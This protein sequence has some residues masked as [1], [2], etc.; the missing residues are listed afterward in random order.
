M[1]VYTCNSKFYVVNI[2]DA[3]ITISWQWD[4]P[5]YLTLSTNWSLNNLD[6]E[7]SRYMQKRSQQNLYNS[8]SCNAKSVVLQRHIQFCH[9]YV[10]YIELW[11]TCL[12]DH[13]HKEKGKVM[14]SDRAGDTDALTPD[15]WLNDLHRVTGE[16]HIPNLHSPISFSLHCL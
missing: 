4:S 12:E 6:F 5:Q 16:K 15:I 2:S 1:Y 9:T 7:N 8:H 10:L 14:C 13:M 3:L 11:H